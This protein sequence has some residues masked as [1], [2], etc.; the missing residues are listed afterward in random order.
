MTIDTSSWGWPQWACIVLILLSFA[1]SAG[2][3]GKH[4]HP[5]NAGWAFIDLSIS[6]FVLIAGG[7]FK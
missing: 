4:R 6:L 2:L 5:H 7:F 3:H 1:S